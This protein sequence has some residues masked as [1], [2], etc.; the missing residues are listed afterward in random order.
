LFATAKEDQPDIE[1]PYEMV[2]NVVKGMLM[3]PPGYPDQR[4]LPCVNFFARWARKR[5]FHNRFVA[6]PSFEDENRDR[7]TGVFPIFKSVQAEYALQAMSTSLSETVGEQGSLFD[8]LQKVLGMCY[9]ELA[10]IP[11]PGCFIATLADGVIRQTAESRDNTPE[12]NPTQ[13]LRLA[14]YFVKPQMLFGLPPACNL[15]FPSMITSYQYSENYWRQPTRSYVNDQFYTSTMNKTPMVA[16]ATT[17]GYPEEINA[18]LHSR[19]EGSPTSTT[20]PNPTSTGKNV[21]VFPEEFFKG[22]VVSRAPVPA[23]FTYLATQRAQQLRNEGAEVAEVAQ[24]EPQLHSLFFLYSQYEHYR[25]RYEQRGGAVDMIWNPYIVPG[26][27]CVIFDHRASALDTV[28]YV[29]S[30]TQ[31]LSAAP[32]GASM[33]TGINYGFGRTLQELFE[34]MRDDMTRLGVVLASAPVDPVDSVR[35]ISQDFDAAEAFYNTLFHGNTNLPDRKASADLRDIVGFVKEDPEA[36]EEE[37]E[38]DDIQIIGDFKSGD[39]K[40]TGVDATGRTVPRTNLG[41]SEAVIADNQGDPRHVEAKPAFE[42]AFKNGIE[43]LRYTSRP[44]C[45]LRQYISFLHGGESMDSLQ[46]PRTMTDPASGATYTR[47]AQVEGE[48]HDFSYG[49]L[50]AST[51]NNTIRS[52]A[53]YYERIRALRP[54]PGDRPPPAQTGATVTA[55]PGSTVASATPVTDTVQ[56]VPA[57]FP[58]TRHDWDERL[59]AYRREILE[60]LSPLR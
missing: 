32:G 42:L 50:I 8:M 24:V 36:Y 15:I 10:M 5:N 44:I 19:H 22:P 60:R 48:R 17:V 47:P 1:R 30:V 26:F 53:V 51:Q 56:G 6:L 34:T 59:L 2:E 37:V 3:N 55:V 14:Q 54:G 11:T 52:S 40:Y 9:S 45:T 46:A 33:R 20:A 31:M 21:L 4:P 25:T 23:W 39:V 58:Q 35:A 12:L 16:A 18:A 13:P 41:A 49:E 7:S 27:P 57:N 43:A 28:G 38:L 29:M